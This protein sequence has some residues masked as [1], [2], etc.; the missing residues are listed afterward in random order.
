MYSELK[1]SKQLSKRLQRDS[2]FHDILYEKEQNYIVIESGLREVKYLKDMET[3]FSDISV[4]AT[5]NLFEEEFP[6]ANRERLMQDRQT[7]CYKNKIERLTKIRMQSLKWTNRKLWLI[8]M[9][10]SRLPNP[11]KI[12]MFENHTFPLDS[13]IFA[14]NINENSQDYPAFWNKNDLKRVKSAIYDSNINMYIAQYHLKTAA[15]QQK[16][17]IGQQKNYYSD[18]LKS[19]GN[20]KAKETL[21]ILDKMSQNDSKN[22]ETC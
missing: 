16:L 20:C 18:W 12:V 7:I 14:D 9:K 8:P 22:E 3:I 10:I 5:E 19:L 4:N 21:E 15:N 13:A 2:Q 11:M 6:I 1:H 17:F